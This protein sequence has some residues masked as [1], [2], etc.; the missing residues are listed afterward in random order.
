MLIYR[1]PEF[2]GNLSVE[3]QCHSLIYLYL[4]MCVNNNSNQEFLVWCYSGFSPMDVNSGFGE[5]SVVGVKFKCAVEERDSVGI[6]FFLHILILL[7]LA[8]FREIA[9]PVHVVEIDGVRLVE[10][11]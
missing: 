6:A 3:N 2:A 4:S 11:E 5:M 9:D 7:V 10:R 8:S 1:F